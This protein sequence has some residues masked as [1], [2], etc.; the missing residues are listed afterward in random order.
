MSKSSTQSSQPRKPSQ[1]RPSAPS[2]LPTT[3]SLRKMVSTQTMTNSTS[4]F[5]SV[6]KR[7]APRTIVCMRASRDY[8]DGWEF[9]LRLTGTGRELRTLQGTS[10]TLGSMDTGQMSRKRRVRR[11]A[12]LS[13]QYMTQPQTR[14]SREDDCRARAQRKRDHQVGRRIWGYRDALD[15]IPA[16]DYCLISPL[17]TGRTREHFPTT[18][19]IDRSVADLFQVRAV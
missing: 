11:V 8:W 18:Y 9:K 5:C 6:C 14:R 4:A 13:I 3:L 16:R 7:V 12:H 19:T 17:G 2:S 10:N 15:R 1:A